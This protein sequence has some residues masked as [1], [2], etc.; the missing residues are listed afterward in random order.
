MDQHLYVLFQM[1]GSF[2]NERAP[3]YCY[4]HSS[5]NLHYY[6]D[7]DQF[8]SHKLCSQKLPEADDC[9]TQ[10]YLF[11]IIPEVSCISAETSYARCLH[12]AFWFDSYFNCTFSAISKHKVGGKKKLLHPSE[13]TFSSGWCS[14]SMLRYT[15]QSI[16]THV[17]IHFFFLFLMLLHY[18]LSYCMFYFLDLKF[19][20]T[21]A[22]FTIQIRNLL[23]KARNF[24]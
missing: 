15:T 6:L 11:L 3:F 12:Q 21:P 8:I 9:Q 4:L 14:I 2:S 16:P 23:S 1:T 7:C 13:N 18:L 22:T 17:Q 10:F 24:F 19:K 20:I 5:E